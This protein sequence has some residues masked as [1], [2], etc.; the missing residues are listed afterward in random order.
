MMKYE[1]SI[2]FAQRMDQEDPIRSYRDRFHF[3]QFNGEDILYFGGNSLGLMPKMAK[4]AV[5]DQGGQAP[6]GADSFDVDGVSKPDNEITLS[7]WDFVASLYKREVAPEADSVRA[8]ITA[9]GTVDV[10]D[11]VMIG[12]NFRN[13][14]PRPGLP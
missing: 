8:D 3:P 7:D 12:A 14:G 1:A 4:D 11:L 6:D 10:D 5:L 9:D 2:E 13:R